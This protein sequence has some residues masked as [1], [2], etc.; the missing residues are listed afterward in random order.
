MNKSE[1][2]KKIKIYANWL[3]DE[4]SQ[5]DHLLKD[6]SKNLCQ[7]IKTE[8]KKGRYSPVYLCSNSILGFSAIEE[9]T[10]N[11]TKLLEALEKF[12]TIFPELKPKTKTH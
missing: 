9:Y 1:M 8:T 7:R 3:E 4:I 12:Y 10:H 11:K 2:H 6:S 5:Y